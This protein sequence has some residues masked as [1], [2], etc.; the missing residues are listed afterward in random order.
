M[1]YS[2]QFM[3]TLG[4]YVYIF[5]KDGD[6]LSA[7]REGQELQYAGKGIDKRTL[8]H[9]LSEEQGGKG[10]TDDDIFIIMRNGEEYCDNTKPNEIAAFAI[11]ALLIKLFNPTDNKVAGRNSDL[12][13]F[14]HLKNLQHQWQLTQIDNV[15]EGFNFF[16]KYQDVLAP[17][18]TWSKSNSE[19]SEYGTKRIQGVEY[20]ICVVHG[21]NGAEATIKV[22]FSKNGIKGLTR[23]DLYEKWLKE[24]HTLKVDPAQAS[25]EY[26][27]ACLG[28]LEDTID[29]FVEASS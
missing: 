2:K 7:L 29:F 24:N 13:V 19:G 3:E 1:K 20:K 28:S 16:R 27:I 10:Y 14:E 12:F 26:E 23:E 18:V 6:V 11:E 8:S 15:V 22:N 17:V 4:S 25:G 21:I 5:S 9:T